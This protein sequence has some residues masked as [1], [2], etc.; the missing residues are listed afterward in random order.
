VSSNTKSEQGI[1]SRLLLDEETSLEQLEQLVDLAEKFFRLDKKTH[2]VVLTDLTRDRVSVKDAVCVFLIAKYF[3]AKKVKVDG[4]PFLAS[5]WVS[6]R[7]IAQVLGKKITD[8]S[9]RLTELVRAGVVSRDKEGR[10][11]INYYKAEAVLRELGQT[12]AQS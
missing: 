6:G 12:Y 11:A 7:E 3:G 5:E 4:E 2:S 10:Y 8:I 1:L 9:G